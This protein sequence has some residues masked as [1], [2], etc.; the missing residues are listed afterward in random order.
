MTCGFRAR[1][2]NR[3]EDAKQN[4]E[5]AD[6]SSASSLFPPRPPRE[7]RDSFRYFGAGERL[8]PSGS[9]N[10]ARAGEKPRSSR[11]RGARRG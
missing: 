4:K 11:V 8:S 6:G 10:A 2:T 5:D 9:P 7:N 3:A 1:D